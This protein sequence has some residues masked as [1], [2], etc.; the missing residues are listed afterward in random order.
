M[1]RVEEISVKL[2]GEK[3]LQTPVEKDCPDCEGTGK[4]DW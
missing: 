1:G 3:R 4:I 2:V